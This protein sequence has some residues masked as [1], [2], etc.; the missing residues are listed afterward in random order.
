MVDFSKLLKMPAGTAVKP[1]A[2]PPGEYP[3]IITGYKLSEAK[4]DKNYTTIITVNVKLAGWPDNIDPSDQIETDGS[5]INLAT[6]STMRRDYY[7]SQLAN[8]DG[9][10]QLL[11]S[12]GFELTGATYEELLAKM[13]GCP[14]IAE[15]GQY[16]NSRT[17]EIG[18]QINRLRGTEA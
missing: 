14:V 1:R 2:L 7:D 10:D 3:G 9:L 18:N 17:M 15:V 8:I 11:M 16:T 6:R 12:L 13:A 4:P 5:Q